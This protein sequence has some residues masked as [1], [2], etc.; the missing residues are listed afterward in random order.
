MG[1][2][3]SLA[4][5][6]MTTR[7]VRIGTA[8]WSVPSQYV[9]D[10]PLGGSH[11]ERYARCLNAVEINSVVLPGAPAQDI[12]TLGTALPRRGF[13]FAVKVPKAITHERRLSD[14]W[15]LARSLCRRDQRARRQ[16]RR[17]YWCSFR[18]H[19]H[20]KSGLPDA[21]FATLRQRIDVASCLRT[22]SCELVRSGRR[23][24]GLPHVA[25]RALPPIP[26]RSKGAREPSW[27]ERTAIIIGGTA[28]RESTIRI[29]MMSLWRSLQSSL[30]LLRINAMSR[31]GAS[32]TTPLRAAALGNA[33]ALRQTAARFTPAAG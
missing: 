9:A 17:H 23:R 15:R 16:A 4:M 12:C 32:S 26:R 21:S 30:G 24:S 14:C 18:R 22:A 7:R 19:L 31:R 10:I 8:G 2:D 5:N 28:R 20:S 3:S 27:L 13:R 25:S 1:Q 29:T 6:S 33:L 11:L